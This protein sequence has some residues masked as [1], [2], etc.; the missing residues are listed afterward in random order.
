V[1]DVQPGWTEL[2]VA[3]R[4]VSLAV[5][6]SLV[7]LASSARAAPVTRTGKVTY[8]GASA[9]Y[10]DR[11]RADGLAPGQ[12]VEIVRKRRALGACEVVAL[13]EHHAQCKGVV[14]EPGDRFSLPAREGTQPAK[15]VT[16]PEVTSAAVLADRRARLEAQ[17]I[18]KVPYDGPRWAGDPSWSASASVTLRHQGYVVLGGGS[19]FQ[20][21]SLDAAATATLGFFPGLFA[22]TAFRVQ[23]DVLAPPTHRTRPDDLVELYVW[24][25]AI[26]LR[27]GALPVVGALGRIRPR[28]APGLVLLDG[29]Q[30]GAS[31]FGGALEVG[32][33]AGALP[34]ILTVAPAADR[35]TAGAY[36]GLDL[37]PTTGFLI[38]PRARIGF[39]TQPD[40]AL[41]RAEVE[42]QTQVLLFN[43]VQ[44]G[45]SARAG[46]GGASPVPVLDAVR[47][48][49]S[50][51]PW[52][53]V[54][55]RGGYR[56]LAPL[57][58]DL[59]LSSAVPS[60]SGAHHADA[61]L[62]W[63]AAS[64][65]T[66]AA[67]GGG[68]LDIRTEAL[69]GWVGPEVGFPR[70]FG[71]VGGVSVLYLEELGS[72]HAGRSAALTASVRPLSILAFTGRASYGEV[73]AIGDAVREG[74]LLL[75]A[76]AP[77]TSWL[78]VRALGQTM[79]VFP[80]FDDVARATPTSL[81]FDVGVTGTL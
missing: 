80:A 19:G 38:L 58:V 22:S 50:V 68:A 16:R 65:V 74:S 45:V 30:V 66:L 78:S 57:V 2:N 28:K 27:E 13:A 12:K 44:G 10:L 41:S 62:T 40:F 79:M 34:D 9:V 11:G 52:A 54:N 15:P 77:L 75:I 64:W 43:A 36:F 24:E 6:V 7:A 69:R 46:V 37:Q 76:D 49:L 61:A 5:L 18:A 21:P 32:G 48:D 31:L 51:S 71:D 14:A 1:H 42:A 23:G 73:S 25:A 26:G 3:Q 56:Y 47:A 29:G 60:V 8:A 20:R 4:L 39:V 59:D 17:P 53:A 35:L 70:M 55:V 63:G 33:Y 72:V 81:L 67:L